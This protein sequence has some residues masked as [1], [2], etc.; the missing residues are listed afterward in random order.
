MASS[1]RATPSASS[2]SAAG[3]GPL[4][5]PCR[6]RSGAERAL[7]NLD[8]SASRNPRGMGPRAAREDDEAA[9]VAALVQRPQHALPRCTSALPAAPRPPR[10]AKAPGRAKAF[11][12][13]VVMARSRLARLV[14]RL[15]SSLSSI[16]PAPPA[17]NGR[18][19]A[20]GRPFDCMVRRSAF[21]VPRGIYQ[22]RYIGALAGPDGSRRFAGLAPHSSGPIRRRLLLG[23]GSAVPRGRP[24]RKP[25]GRDH[26]AD[27]ARRGSLRRDHPKAPERSRRSSVPSGGPAVKT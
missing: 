4:P 12:A 26:A 13:A 8:R 7:A 21:G 18:R 17:A 19:N 11:G 9:R 24:G 22:P 1:S 10:R 5:R 2:F 27:A 16:S 23:D 3:R 14:F 25:S 6:A 15:L 20:E